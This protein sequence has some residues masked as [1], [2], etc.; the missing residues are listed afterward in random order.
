MGG[1]MTLPSDKKSL[2]ERVDKTLDWLE[3]SRDTWK[4]KA[5]MAKEELKKR[6]LAVKRARES[7][8]EY[9]EQFEQ[10]EEVRRAYQAEVDQKA[11]KI[12]R[13]EE[14]LANAQR[15]IEEL[16]KSRCTYNRQTSLSYVLEQP[17]SP[18][19]DLYEHGLYKLYRDSQCNGNFSFSRKN[20][21]GTFSRNMYSM[22]NEN[23]SVQVIKA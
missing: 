1:N 17:N 20:R 12:E 21:E 9:K 16:K 5:K 4:N 18:G 7:R 8:D 19:L 2:P 6:T 10:A 15:E 11:S 3:T 13:L 22:G 23:R 14:Q